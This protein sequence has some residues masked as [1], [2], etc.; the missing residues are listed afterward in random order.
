[1]LETYRSIPL[2]L[3][4][5]NRYVPNTIV[6]S[7]LDARGRTFDLTITDGGKEADLSEALVYLA[8]HHQRVG[9][10][11]VRK[12]DPV[13]ASKGTFSCHFPTNMAH[14]GTVRAAV[15]VTDEG[16]NFFL[17]SLEFNIRIESAVFNG[18]EAD[19]CDDFSALQ[20]A[21]GNLQNVLNTALEEM[22]DQRDVFDLLMHEFERE[23]RESE[24]DRNA[25][26]QAAE[27]HRDDLFEQ[28]QQ[29]RQSTFELSEAQRQDTFETTE[30]Q[31]RD[32]FEANEAQR[33]ESSDQAVK[34]ANDAAEIVEEAYK[35]NFN[36]SIELWVRNHL[37][38]DEELGILGYQKWLENPYLQDSEFIQAVMDS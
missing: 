14:L 5:A 3:D 30:A 32:T 19:T 37:N 34:R 20:E 36:P 8:W 6:S 23:Y 29:R 31:R 16:P 10:S 17:P 9:N 1:M 25:R 35:G 27:D 26:Y 11:G 38:K 21:M 15:I 28:A 4:M 7:G 2:T 24:A 13:D 18:Q 12:L 22:Q 33:Q